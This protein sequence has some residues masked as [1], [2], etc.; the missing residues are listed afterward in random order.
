[1][2]KLQ[3]NADFTIKYMS[4]GTKIMVKNFELYNNFRKSLNDW[5]VEFLPTT[6]HQI[7]STGLFLLV[8]LRSHEKESKSRWNSTRWYLPKFVNQKSKKFEE[9]GSYITSFTQGTVKMQNLKKTVIDYTVPKWRPYYESTN[10]ITQ[11]RRCQIFGHGIRNC[12]MKFKCSNCGLDHP[13]EA[14]KSPVRKL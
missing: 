6:Q 10:N 8:F 2:K 1:M 13:T 7:S 4:T 3:S 9:K 5:N 11:C 14:C 12:N